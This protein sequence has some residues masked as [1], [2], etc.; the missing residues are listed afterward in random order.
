[1][2]SLFQLLL[3]VIAIYSAL[4]YED[5]VRLLIPL[6]C[7]ILMLVVIRIDKRLVEKERARKNFLKTEIDKFLKKESPT[8]IEHDFSLSSRW[9]GQKMNCY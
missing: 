2:L 4:H 5:A 3:A 8:V 6:G 1:M 9:F 7:L